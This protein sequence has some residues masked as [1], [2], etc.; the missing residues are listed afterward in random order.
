MTLRII[1]AQEV[2]FEGSAKAVTL[3]GYAGSFTVL[4]NHAPLIAVLTPGRVRYLDD[5]DHEQHLEIKGGL[6]DVENNKVDVCVY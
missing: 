2:L 4:R 6:V 3:P 1:S 5:Q